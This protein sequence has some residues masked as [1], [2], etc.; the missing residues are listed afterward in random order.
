MLKKPRFIMGLSK[1]LGICRFRLIVFGGRDKRAV[2][3][4]VRKRPDCAEFLGLRF[5][6]FLSRPVE[7]A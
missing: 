5:S 4:P 1:P 2:M 3:T 6:D 7:A